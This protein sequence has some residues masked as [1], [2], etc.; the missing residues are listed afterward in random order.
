MKNIAIIGGGAAGFF[1][2][3]NLAQKNPDYKITIYEKSNKLL[4]KVKVSGG[5]RCNVTHAC[6]DAGELIEFYPRGGKEL[7]P[8]FKKFQPQNTVEWFE[9]RGVKIKKENDGRMFPV[10]NN[11][12]TII[13]CFL[14]EAEKYGVEIKMGYA[15]I[16]LEKS[17]NDQNWKLAFANERTEMADSVMM[18][19]GSSESVW[20]ILKK[21]GHTII[22]PVP[23]LF[24]FHIADK[25]IDG[26][27]GL[28]VP[29]ATVHLKN[30]DTK[31]NGPLL[32]T[33]WGMS[34]PA[35]LKSS[36]WEA[37]FLNEKNY[38]T[39]VIINFTGQTKE[40][41][42]KQLAILRDA[43]A[44]KLAGTI[45][46]FG[47]P[48]R[49]W[50]QLTDHLNISDRKWAGLGNKDLDAL[51][52]ELCAAEYKINGKTTFKE[53]FVTCGGV[54]LEEVNLEKFESKIHPG[55]FFG[56]EILNIDAVTGGFNFQAAWTGGWIV[57]TNI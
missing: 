41:I 21:L 33:H 37:I 13:D 44:K 8:A 54:K 45:A 30:R 22:P 34:G 18:A 52:T 20:E 32:I 39:K 47:L 24:T 5:G 15:L 14:N 12:Q 9:K 3:I 53:E 7:V 16:S 10:T 56:G 19:A 26:L 31:T 6:F 28:S 27:M 49:L 23:S 48:T 55:L 51:A 42:R 57:S 50:K 29:D 38:H 35:I 25:R 40:T 1:A 11:S 46:Q 43:E 4:S 36:A 2:A 17:E